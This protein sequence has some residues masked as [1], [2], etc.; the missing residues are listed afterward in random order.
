MPL[1]EA[2]PKKMV[3]I[4]ADLEP[5]AQQS[6][7]EVLLDNVDIFVCGTEDIPRVA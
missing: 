7:L 4:G 6:M 2:F 1:A 3:A 5:K